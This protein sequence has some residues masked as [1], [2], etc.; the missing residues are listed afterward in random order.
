MADST[1]PV[2]GVTSTTSSTGDTTIS[3]AAS[4]ILGKDD[5]LK[6]LITELQYQDP[7]NPVDNKE[8]ISEMAQFSSL[9]QMQNLNDNFQNLVTLQNLSQINFA[10]NLMNHRIVGTDANGASVDGTVDNV[11]VS[12]G[13]PSVVVGSST[14]SMNNIIKI[15]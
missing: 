8:F 13:S 9:E 7:L 5:F 11:T 12:S 6:L 14:V 10:V 4:S 15:Y 1:T 3:G 2:S